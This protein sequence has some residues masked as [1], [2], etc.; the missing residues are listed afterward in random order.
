MGSLEGKVALVTGA[1]RGIGRAIALELAR[2][3][4]KVA[5]NYRSG[6]AQA[7]EVADEIGALRAAAVAVPSNGKSIPAGGSPVATLRALALGA[8]GARGAGPEAIAVQADVSR[9]S[10]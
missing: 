7:R 5:V 9:S 4:A 2:E 3:G 6:E 8:E 1:S 10:Q